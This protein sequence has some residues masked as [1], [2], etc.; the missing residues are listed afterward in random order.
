MRQTAEKLIELI[1]SLPLEIL[2]KIP[3]LERALPPLYDLIQI[4]DVCD[5]KFTNGKCICGAKE[6]K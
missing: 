4:E 2:Q 6:E 5:H 1:N 3:E